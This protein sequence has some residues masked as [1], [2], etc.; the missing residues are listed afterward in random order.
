MRREFWRTNK[1]N[2]ICAR[3]RYWKHK[4]FR[5]GCATKEDAE[6]LEM[7]ETR[8][9][10]VKQK[11]E[12]TADAWSPNTH[13]SGLGRGRGRPRKPFTVTEQK[14]PNG[15]KISFWHTT[16]AGTL[17]HR[18]AYHKKKISLGDTS[19]KRAA[20][21]A[22]AYKALRDAATAY[23]PTGH[24]CRGGSG[25]GPVQYKVAPAPAPAPQPNASGFF[26]PTWD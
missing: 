11:Y 19:E 25:S 16:L 13:R 23:G 3:I 15:Q 26:V 9:R 18:A 20:M 2:S 12:N 1:V 24:W 10:E 4:I 21:Y 7:Y 14:F 6:K 8:L 17:R 5:S 22:E